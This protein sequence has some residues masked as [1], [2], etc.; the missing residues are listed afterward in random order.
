MRT[1]IQKR[2]WSFIPKAPSQQANAEL[3]TR[4]IAVVV[5]VDPRL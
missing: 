4:L 3:S 5:N 1:A 2:I